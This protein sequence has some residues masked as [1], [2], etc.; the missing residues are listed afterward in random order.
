LIDGAGD[1]AAYPRHGDQ[2]LAVPATESESPAGRGRV[3]PGVLVH[4]LL[5]PRLI[6]WAGEQLH[7]EVEVEREFVARACVYDV[8]NLKPASFQDASGVRAPGFEIIA[9]SAP[10]FLRRKLIDPVGET[11]PELFAA[12]DGV[13]LAQLWE[14]RPDLEGDSYSQYGR[15]ARAMFIPNC[16]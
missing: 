13:N 7:R 14:D 15:S 9:P 5:R 1:G 10:P 6:A 2:V 3:V 4:K 16:L 8:A 12:K 11:L